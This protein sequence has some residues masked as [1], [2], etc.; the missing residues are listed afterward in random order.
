[1]LVQASL[2]PKGSFAAGGLAAFSA[3]T[4]G[5]GHACSR[6]VFLLVPAAVLPVMT[7]LALVAAHSIGPVI[8]GSM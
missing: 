6:I 7:A 5:G 1:V 2:N 8:D 4:S 3:P